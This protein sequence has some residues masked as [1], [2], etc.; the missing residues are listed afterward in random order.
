VLTEWLSE[1]RQTGRIGLSEG[2]GSTFWYGPEQRPRADH[3]PQARQRREG[4]VK[5]QRLLKLPR[6]PARIACVDISNIQGQHAGGASWSS[7]GAARTRRP[8]AL[9]IRVK[10]EPDDPAMMA[11]VVERLVKNDP[12]LASGLDLLLLDGG[13]GQLNR[14]LRLLEEL[15]YAERLPLAS[16]AKERDADVG[17]KGKGLYEKIYLPGRKNPLFL[18]RHPDILHL[19]QRVRD[20]AHRF[21]ISHYQNVHRSALSP[22]RSMPLR[23]SDRKENR[24]SSSISEALKRSMRPRWTSWRK[25]DCRAPLRKT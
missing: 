15:G 24:C 14:I 9:R 2:N 22:R 16:I 25:Q 11:E 13:K 7:T 17:E 5:V 12:E 21:A 19:L 20:E 6:A 4:L 23:V 1:M 10:S 18:H 8:T 3:Q